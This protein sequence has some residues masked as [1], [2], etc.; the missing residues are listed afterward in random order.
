MEST[1]IKSVIKFENSKTMNRYVEILD[2]LSTTQSIEFRFMVRRLHDDKITSD[3]IE[4]DTFKIT[5]QDLD[6]ILGLVKNKNA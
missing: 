3:G 5:N 2:S 4:F 1:L 6:S